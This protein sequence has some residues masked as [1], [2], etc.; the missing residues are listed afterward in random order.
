M[1]YIINK[2]ENLREVSCSEGNEVTLMFTWSF[3]F[4]LQ[5]VLR[6]STRKSLQ[7]NGNKILLKLQYQRTGL[8]S[9]RLQ[10]RL[11]NTLTT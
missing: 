2:L 5:C 6:A 3:R 7:V 8:E 1:P 9:D 11:Y 4:T 10:A